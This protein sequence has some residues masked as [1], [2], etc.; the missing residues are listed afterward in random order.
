MKDLGIGAL[1]GLLFGC[2]LAISGMTLP[3][4][5]LGFLDVAGRWDASLAFVMVGAIGVHA[6]AYRLI[7]RRGRPWLA[8]H[9]Q[10]PTRK[11]L[12][13]P[14]L[15][16]AALF[17]V[18]WGMGGFCPGPALVSLGGLAPH[19]LAFVVAMSVGMLLHRVLLA[20]GPRDDA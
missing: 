11:D 2:G 5:V 17:G 9:F 4:K 13:A 15:I 3:S 1:V 12:D 16:G 14:L 10:R 20:R 6:L 8:A 7:D 19:A 18:G